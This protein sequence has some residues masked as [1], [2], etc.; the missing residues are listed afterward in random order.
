MP[1][2]PAKHEKT[3][4]QTGGVGHPPH[5][6]GTGHPP[7]VSR[8]REGAHQGGGGDGLTLGTGGAGTRG[9]DRG[10]ARATVEATAMTSGQHREMPPAAMAS[11]MAAVAA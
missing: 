9:A 8:R 10:E 2:R 5:H 1:A 11:P 6:G 3:G 7:D 4:A